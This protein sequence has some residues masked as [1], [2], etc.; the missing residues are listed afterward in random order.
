MC[1]LL[2]FFSLQMSPMNQMQSMSMGMGPMRGNGAAGM[3]AGGGVMNDA[4]QMSHQMTAMNPMAKMQG[5]ANNGYPPRRMAPY[6]NPQMHAAQKRAA[7]YPMNHQANPQNVPQH[8][9]AAAAAAAA[10]GQM[11]YN[12][13]HQHPHHSTHQPNGVPVPMQAGY[14]RTGGQMNPYGRGPG[15]MMGPVGSAAGMMPQQRA[16]P[17]SYG[18]GAP[19]GAHAQQFY[20]GGGGNAVGGMGPLGGMGGGNGG[21]AGPGAGAGTPNA[22]HQNAQG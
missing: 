14:G 15:G 7:M 21:P 19:M 9:A 10:A 17:G 4:S 3:G 12:P 8:H 6:P 5:M 22:Y 11:Q 2:Y 16:V 18:G 20:G 1:I 13:H